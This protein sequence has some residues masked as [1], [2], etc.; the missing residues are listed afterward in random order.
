VSNISAPRTSPQLMK[1]LR[2]LKNLSQKKNKNCGKLPR[3]LSSCGEE[4][5]Y[6]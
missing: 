5:Y 6:R 3:I 2:V 4:I 1:L